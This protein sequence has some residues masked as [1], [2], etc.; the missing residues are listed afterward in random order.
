MWCSA[1]LEC[2]DIYMRVKSI[3]ATLENENDAQIHSNSASPK[4][5]KK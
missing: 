1:T 3:G 5:G 4:K 2:Y